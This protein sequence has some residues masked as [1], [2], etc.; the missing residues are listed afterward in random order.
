MAPS[1]WRIGL[2]LLAF[3]AKRILSTVVH[4]DE[5]QVEEHAHK[6]VQVVAILPGPHKT[7]TS[8]FQSELSAKFRAHHPALANWSWP[9]PSPEIWNKHL[10][11]NKSSYPFAFAKGHA[12]LASR[13]MGQVDIFPQ[14]PLE[15]V[16]QAYRETLQQDWEAGKNLILAAEHLDALASEFLPSSTAGWELQQ[17]HANN[18]TQTGSQLLWKR[19]Q[20]ILPSHPTI[21]RKIIGGVFYRDS[22]TD[23]LISLC[24]Q[25]DRNGDTRLSDCI[26]SDHKF[27]NYHYWLNGLKLAQVLQEN[28]VD[29]V[30]I[31]N[32]AGLERANNQSPGILSSLDLVVACEM[33]QVPCHRTALGQW[34][35]QGDPITTTHRRVEP[36]RLNVQQ[37]HGLERID[38]NQT[39]L[40]SIDQI[41]KEYDCQVAE[42][43]LNQERTTIRYLYFEAP[44]VRE[45]SRWMTQQLEPVFLPVVDRVQS[46]VFDAVYG[47]MWDEL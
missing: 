32:T 21:Q 25:I 16:L 42:K 5:W 40:Q 3:Q 24:H 37:S 1:I 27:K 34:H 28:N 35:L 45:C 11:D 26:L 6:R 14:I 43:Y 36:D 18:Y 38:L 19:I 20:D 7:G 12:L 30:Y 9:V 2:L 47:H 10:K 44:F 8:T 46:I 17:Q 33:M 39:T 29:E 22:K 4:G 41:L 15:P 31:L 13:L 23:H